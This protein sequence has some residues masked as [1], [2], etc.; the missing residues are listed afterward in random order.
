MTYEISPQT[1]EIFRIAKQMKDE[2]KFLSDM[3][4]IATRIQQGEDFADDAEYQQWKKEHGYMSNE[5]QVFNY[6]DN[7]VRT[8]LI[9]GEPWFVLKDVC[10]VLSLGSPHKVAD[11]LDGDERNQIPL[12]DGLGRQ[13]ETTII[14]ES[15]LYNVILRSDKPEAKPFRKWVTGEVLPSIRKHGAYLTTETAER[16]LRD[17]RAIVT[18]VNALQDEQEKT[19]QLQK[20]VDSLAEEN[21][22][23]F[24]L[25]QHNMQ[26]AKVIDAIASTPTMVTIGE[27]AKLLRQGGVKIGQNRLLGWM[28]ANNWLICRQGPDYNMPTQY[29]IERRYLKLC[30]THWPA[31]DGGQVFCKRP[32]VT[33]EGQRILM[34][35]FLSDF[36]KQLMKY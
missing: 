6:Q 9:D 3:T 17:P 24:R 25:S 13:Q 4:E 32:M 31:E 28:R 14:N 35:C 18:L 15:G 23:L 7:E 12:T 33:W 22:G 26:A 11:R 19:G 34:E 29:A 8:V 30:E 2:R 36:S 1:A 16:L 21:K 10:S 27:M 20:R 5:L